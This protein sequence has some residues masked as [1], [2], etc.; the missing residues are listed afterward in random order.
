M[1]TNKSIR[2]WW[3]LYTRFS[4]A[5]SLVAMIGCIIAAAFGLPCGGKFDYLGL[6]I[7][8]LALMVTFVVAWQIWQTIAS[9][10]EIKDARAAAE[11]SEELVKRIEGIEAQLKILPDTHSA[12]ISVADG[13]SFLLNNRH[14]KA[15]HLFA[16]G[17]IDSLKDINDKGRC[18]MRALANLNHCMG[19]D[20]NDASMN[21]YKE[22][23]EGVVGRLSE[24]EDALRNADQE[25]KI[26]QSLARQQ[27]DA[28][29]QS[30]REKGFK[31]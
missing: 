5:I 22:K 1:K 10:E 13:L 31:I 3:C 17:I 29:K 18:A 6:I 9:R 27:I 21:E 2:K 24:I 14:F 15:F 4:A 8:I 11:K 12:Y 26:F 7:G 25:N 23:W 28:F 20:E 19:F 30:A 16:T